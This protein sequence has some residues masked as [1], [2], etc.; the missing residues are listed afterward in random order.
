MNTSGAP[1]P[2]PNP[3]GQGLP[4][5]AGTMIATMVS[6]LLWLAASWVAY[7]LFA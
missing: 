2:A 3:F 5:L 1:R 6:A 4:L 7:A